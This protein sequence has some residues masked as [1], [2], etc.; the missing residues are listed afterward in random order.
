MFYDLL[1]ISVNKEVSAHCISS[2]SEFKLF[3]ECYKTIADNQVRS[4]IDYVIYIAWLSDFD[5]VEIAAINPNS[6][7]ILYDNYSLQWPLVNKL[8]YNAVLINKVYL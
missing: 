8:V 1:A 6:L 3:Q 7:C 5:C 2:N 4:A